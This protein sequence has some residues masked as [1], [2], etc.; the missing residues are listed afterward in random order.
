MANPDEVGYLLAARLLAGGPGGD[1]SGSTFYQGG[2]ALLLVPAFWLASD[3]G[4]VYRLI[5]GIGSAVA[6][7]AFPLAYLA[8]RS[9]GMAVRPALLLAFAAG[10]SPSL[11]AF[12]GLALVDAVLPTLLLGWLITLYDLAHRG[13]MRAS[14]LAGALAG[15]MAATHMRGYVV[16]AVW[17]LALAGL[18]VTRRIAPKAAF[19][20]A[21]VGGMTALAGAVLNARLAAD[22]YP[23]GARNLSGLLVDR[24]TGFDG[25]S[26]ALAGAAGQIWYLVVATWGLAG[27][28]LVAA[29]V[30]AVR[31]GAA[32]AHRVTSAALLTITL[33]TAYASSAALP[34]EHRVGNYAY[35]RYLAFVALAWTLAGLVALLRARRTVVPGLVLGTVALAAATGGG[36]ALYAG[37]RLHRYNFIAFDFPEV[38]FLSGV[39]DRLDMATASWTA[40]ALLACF[41]VA[42]LTPHRVRGLLTVGALVAVNAAFAV[43][44]AP[45]APPNPD[46]GRLP[47]PPPGRVALDNRIHWRLWVQVAYRVSWTE[48]ERFDGNR[49]AVPHGVC[50][51]VLPPA[52]TPPP[53]WRAAGSRPE[54]TLWTSPH[55]PPG[56][57]PG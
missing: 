2:Y 6:A 1:Y 52:A 39:R 57:T 15:F 41:A 54:W 38:I 42:A 19:T 25:Q 33:G 37:D 27:V 24:L 35:G 17:A 9:L 18:A 16:F 51:T 53:G 4:T 49:Q 28:G 56:R 29:A 36:A 20:G 7:A 10:A 34:D 21:I 8:L 47:Q 23:G 43:H 13:S 40:V 12:S 11:L 46:P 5:V 3:P 22:L 55:C 26:W 48:L 44:I 31:R 50:S 45:Q 32:L 30:T 14:A